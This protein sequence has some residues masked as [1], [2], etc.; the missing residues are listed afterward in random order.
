M[1]AAANILMDCDF[2]SLT[3]TQV[4]ERHFSG[5]R[6][7]EFDPKTEIYFADCSMVITFKNTRPT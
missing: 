5:F 6:R 2:S 1:L 3:E 7:V 4:L